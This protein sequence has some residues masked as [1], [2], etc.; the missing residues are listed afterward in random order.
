LIYV[1]TQWLAS[2]AMVVANVEMRFLWLGLATAI[3]VATVVT[4][5]RQRHL[6]AAIEPSDL[7]SSA[8]DRHG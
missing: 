2:L 8:P 7:E 6:D 5:N 1:F 3:L 4:I